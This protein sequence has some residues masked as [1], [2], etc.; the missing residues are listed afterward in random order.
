MRYWKWINPDGSINSVQSCSNDKNVVEGATEITSDI[1]V[2]FIDSLPTPVPPS[3]SRDII[4]ELDEL[5]K[6][7]AVLENKII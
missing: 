4:V 3:P 1:F 6:R 7:V 5:N 2:T